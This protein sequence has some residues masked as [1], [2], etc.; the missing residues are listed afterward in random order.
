IHVKEGIDQ[1]MEELKATDRTNP[2]TLE[3]FLKKYAT[4]LPETNQLTVKIQYGLV[5]L[6]K[7]QR[8]ESS[9]NDAAS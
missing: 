1:I 5:N 6:F 9:Q 8:N 2:E 3:D 7:R 4:L